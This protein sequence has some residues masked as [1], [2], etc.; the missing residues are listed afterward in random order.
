MTRAL[1]SRPE[2][3]AAFVEAAATMRRLQKDFFRTRGSEAFRAARAAEARFDSM[4]EG[5]QHPERRKPTPAELQRPL[6]AAT[7]PRSICAICKHEVHPADLVFTRALE[8][9]HPSCKEPSR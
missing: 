5:I 3:I 4:L 1:P 8:P 2:E 6:F 7:F 9:R